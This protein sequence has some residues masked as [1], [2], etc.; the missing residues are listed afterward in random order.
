MICIKEY[1]WDQEF[2]YY[3]AT[4]SFRETL[5]K[6]SDARMRFASKCTFLFKQQGIFRR[7]II[8]ENLKTNEI[9]TKAM[10][11]TFDAKLTKSG[12]MRKS[13]QKG[14]QAKDRAAS[15]NN[16]VMQLYQTKSS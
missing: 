4:M 16:G 12:T 9:V 7:E 5:A 1:I 6:I 14:K 13:K 3:T 15:Q 10:K 2:A 11:L 8:R